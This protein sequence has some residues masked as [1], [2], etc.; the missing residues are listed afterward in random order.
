MCI[1]AQNYTTVRT[2]LLQTLTDIALPKTKWIIVGDFNNVESINDHNLRYFGYLMG[3]KEL[4]AWNAFMANLGL[5]DAWNLNEFKRIENKN[6]TWSRKV[7][8]PIWSRLDRF[9]VDLG[10]SR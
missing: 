4:N 2:R 10:Y 3:G 9:Y 8:S 5:L 1:Y 6:F 7:P